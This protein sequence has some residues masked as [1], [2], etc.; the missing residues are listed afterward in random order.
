[1]I[2]VIFLLL[3]SNM[4]REH[5]LNYFNLLDACFQSGIWSIFSSVL[6]VLVF[7]MIIMLL[8]GIVFYS[9][10]LGCMSIVLFKPYISSLI[11]LFACSVNNWERST[12]TVELSHLLYYCFIYFFSYICFRY[13]DTIFRCIRT[14]NCYWWIKFFFLIKEPSLSSSHNFYFKIQFGDF[15]G[16]AVGKNP[17]ASAGDTSSSPGPGRSHMSQSN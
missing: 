8:L 14:S 17:P 12:M 1:M 10:P 15:P 4:V 9:Y 7:N 5:V 11:V 2:L 6:C 16:G 3:I 13:F